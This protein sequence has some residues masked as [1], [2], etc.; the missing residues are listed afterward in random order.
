MGL[1]HFPPVSLVSL[2]QVSSFAYAINQ[3]DAFILT[4]FPLLFSTPFSLKSPTCEQSFSHQLY[5]VDS[6]VAIFSYSI[7]CALSF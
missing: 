3:T 4:S 2:C 1:F 6:Q 7:F 5:V